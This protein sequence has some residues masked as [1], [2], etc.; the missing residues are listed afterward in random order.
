VADLRAPTPSAAAELVVPV[1]VKLITS[2]ES[3]HLRMIVHQHRIM[4]RL[5]ERVSALR[6]RLRDPGRR[7]ADLFITLDDR[8]ERIKSAL[9]N[10]LTIQRHK[11]LNLNIR[12][13]HTAPLSRI[14]D[15]RFVLE[16]LQKNMIAELRNAI[17]GLKRRVRSDMAI[18]DTLSPLAILSRGYSIVRSLPEG[19]IIR[20]ADAVTVGSDVDVKVSQGGFHAQVTGVY[21]ERKR[22]GEREI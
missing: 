4:E 10:K 13:R 14:R 21:E 19:L 1:K 15:G 6:E 17:E 22:D 11:E 7:I 2:L 16:N 8:C 20:R 18:L 5:H 12:L 3:L 9:D